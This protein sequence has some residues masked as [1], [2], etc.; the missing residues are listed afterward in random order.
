MKKNNHI[1]IYGCCVSR[2]GFSMHEDSGGYVIDKYIQGI[3]PFSAILEKQGTDQD[4][5]CEFVKSL[6]DVSNFYKKMICLDHCGGAFEYLKQVKS[7]WIIL[8]N[9]PFRYDLCMEDCKNPQQIITNSILRFIMKKCKDVIKGTQLEVLGKSSKE[10]P[11]DWDNNKFEEKVKSFIKELRKQ[12]R[13]KSIILVHLKNVFSYTSAGDIHVIAEKNKKDLKMENLRMEKAW[14]IMKRLL[15][16]AHIIEFP[17]TTLGNIKHKWG[18]GGLHYIDEYYNYFLK[19]IDIITQ[20][21]LSA[22]KEKEQLDQICKKYT[23]LFWDI[24]NKNINHYEIKSKQ[25]HDLMTRWEAYT[26]YSSK[27]ADLDNYKQK[28]LDFMNKN[29]FKKCA[30]YG[31][32]YPIKYLLNAF[33]DKIQVDYIIENKVD[34]YEGIQCYGRDI[35]VS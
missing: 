10:D 15:P 29:N 1:S 17:F 30:I 24:Y 14:E 19:S 12:Y 20:Q 18:R 26:L 23:Q 31:T 9:G 22:K 8:D 6:T 11:L 27:L 21:R 2:D 34:T 32:N 7:D 5:F 25:T 4:S 33:K 35:M 28:F 16:K 3:S 13:E